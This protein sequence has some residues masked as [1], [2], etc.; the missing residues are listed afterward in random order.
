MLFNAA[1]EL[2]EEGGA[3]LAAAFRGP[4]QFLWLDV[5]GDDTPEMLRVL[6]AFELNPLAHRDSQR[7]RHPPKYEAFDEHI[8]MV[9]HEL[10]I[11][12][13]HTAISRQPLSLFA[14][15]GYLITRH[16]SPSPGVEQY[17]RKVAQD[18]RLAPGGIGHLCYVL[19]RGIV[20]RYTPLMYEVEQRLSAI[21]DEIFESTDDE[22]LSELINY[23][24]QLKKAQRSFVFQRDVIEELCRNPSPVILDFDEHELTDLLDHFKRLSSLA[25]LYQE[26]VRDLI[27]GFISVSSHRMNEIM[28]VLTILTA[29]FLPLT[30]V[31]GIYGMNFDNM[32]ELHWR[33][34]YFFVLGFM[35][36]IVTA[37]ML[38]VRRKR[39]L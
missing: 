35:A 32:P 12:A 31:A 4:G 10:V 29:I 23:G 9:M 33:H 7:P 39:W 27:S 21:E 26:L 37:A 6:D 17:W 5:Q 36:A 22:L 20:D 14:N 15:N 28:K 1:G 11:D 13:S 18:G 38:V 34:G 19:L 2:L 24:T 25:N 8:F 16:I 30:L 3:A